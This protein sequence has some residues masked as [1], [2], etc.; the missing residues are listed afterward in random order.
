MSLSAYEQQRSS[1]IAANQ[2]KLA[3]LGLLTSLIA[4]DRT[5]RTLIKGVARI[6][7]RSAS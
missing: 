4:K 2:S 5:P 1:N 3:E 6:A 7:H